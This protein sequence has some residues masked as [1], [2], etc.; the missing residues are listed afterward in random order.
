[1]IPMVDL[2]AQYERLK[3]EIDNQVL[4]VLAKGHYILGPQV[5]AF[6]KETAAY[7]GVKHAIGVASGTD[8]LYL[9][10]ME[11]GIKA[12]DEV[13]TTPFTFIAACEAICYLGAK[14]VFVDIE[15]NTFNMDMSQVEAAI[16]S[17]T[18]AIIPVHLYGLATNLDPVLAI[19]KKHNLLLIEDCAQSFGATYKNQQTGSIGDVG[20]FSF[21]P[22]KTLGAFGDGGMITTNC[23]ERADHLL[24]LRAHGSKIRYEHTEIGLNS[25]LDEIQAAVLR[26]KLKYIDQFNKERQQVAKLYDEL[27]ANTSLTIPTGT[28]GS[29]HVYH[30]YTILTDH[31]EAIMQ[32]LA[33]EGIASSIHYPKSIHKQPVF[34]EAYRH[35]S[36]PISEAAASRC[37]SLPIYPEMT[38]AQVQQVAQV[39]R[40]VILGQ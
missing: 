25:R 15:A 33:K 6:E 12:G 13:I 31:R 10:L 8:A 2:P 20:C 35:L 21:Y 22:T 9:A 7:L 17:K 16:T 5:Q 40:E 23:S 28:P 4:E 39:I 18:K 36:F 26:V 27:L 14:P 32:A 24:R 1:M 37:L 30:Q 3:S 29:T 19:C 38:P 11:Q 34:A